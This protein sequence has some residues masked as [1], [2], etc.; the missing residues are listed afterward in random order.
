MKK[1]LFLLSCV[2]LMASAQAQ[3]V[4]TPAW[5]D[6]LELP[7]DTKEA[8]TN[9]V[10]AFSKSGDLFVSGICTTDFTFGNSDITAI[11]GG[12]TYL[13]K[14][15]ATGEKQW[16]VS[17]FGAATPTA[18]TTDETGNV[19]VAGAFADLV[20]FNS[21][22]GT[23]Q[24]REGIP[25]TT[26]KNAGFIAKYNATGVLQN[27]ESFVPTQFTLP[28]PDDFGFFTPTFGITKLAVING[29]IYASAIV[30]NMTVKNGIEIKGALA[31]NAEFGLYLDAFAGVIFYMNDALTVEG[32]AA[33]FRQEDNLPTNYDVT[34]VNFVQNGTDL[35]VAFNAPGKQ[36]L[37]TP[38]GST[39]VNFPLEENGDFK[40]G[41]YIAEIDAAGN[42]L[43]NAQYNA[44][45]FESF[46]QIVYSIEGMR[47]ADNLL[48]LNGS[49]AKNLPFDTNI[50]TNG[51][52]DFYVAA[53][54]LSDLS[55][56]KVN[57]KGG[58]DAEKTNAS[59]WSGN[60]LLMSSNTPAA[61]TLFTYDLVGNDGDLTVTNNV[62]S[63]GIASSLNKI[64]FISTD[65]TN[66]D[67]PKL[68]IEV[69]TNTDPSG[70]ENV[71]GDIK[72]TAYPNPATTVINLSELG[73]VSV[74]N[75]AGSLVLQANAVKELPVASLQNGIYYAKVKTA[76]GDASFSFIKK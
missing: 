45:S 33:A 31:H 47:V 75:A 25:G 32:I 65:V 46:S 23:S 2:A 28:S 72:V 60:T 3:L 24:Q 40:Q 62:F 39:A 8:A 20:T 1:S 16:G 44:D 35:L 10:A 64:A 37:I 63:T 15:S 56:N 59:A 52:E 27:V 51:K 22:D 74:Y 73:D 6:A 14:Y 38:A 17:F 70:I 12:S 34:A 9:D 53:L 19:Y 42:N 29:K 71:K 66:A 7:R 50:G 30:N 76:K 4:T 48:V 67:E 55:V 61:S 57:G 36:N 68:K 13:I 11:A 69:V 54:N 58:L 5:S 49:F 21:T 41:Y 26:A 43:K 18:I